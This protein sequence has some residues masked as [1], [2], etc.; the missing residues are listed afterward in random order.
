MWAF[1]RIYIY[2][3]IYICIECTVL[4]MVH[5]FK[6]RHIVDAD[7]VV[8]SPHVAKAVSCSNNIGIVPYSTSLFLRFV[9]AVMA[10]VAFL[11]FPV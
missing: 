1:L 10:A 4:W 6:G 9:V 8:P 11:Q 5:D 7:C 2:I 3:Y